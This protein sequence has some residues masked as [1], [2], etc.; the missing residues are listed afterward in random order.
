MLGYGLVRI[1]PYQ[2]LFDILH[3]PESGMI[4]SGVFAGTHATGHAVSAAITF[5]AQKGASP[6][7]MVWR[8]GFAGIIVVFRTY[9][10][11]YLIFFRIGLVNAG[12]VFIL[13]PFPY[14][15]CHI[16]KAV[17]IRRKDL[18]GAVRA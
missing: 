17:A 5:I 14:I 2:R 9:R 1:N 6:Y 16:V 18:T 11:F 13:T 7:N 8:P 12:I 3:T 10:I 15:S 4:K